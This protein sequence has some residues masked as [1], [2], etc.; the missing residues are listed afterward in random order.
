MVLRLSELTEHLL[1]FTDIP[2]LVVPTGVT[3]LGRARVRSG[4]GHG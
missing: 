3:S 1:E 4:P 2:V